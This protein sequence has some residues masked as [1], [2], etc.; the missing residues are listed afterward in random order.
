MERGGSA[1][2]AAV[3][4]VTGEAIQAARDVMAQAQTTVPGELTPL[5]ARAKRFE[6]PDRDAWKAASLSAISEKEQ[7]DKAGPYTS[8]LSSS[9]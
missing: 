3:G 8:F 7:R 6:K 4:Y 1:I 9:T 5:Q 2:Y